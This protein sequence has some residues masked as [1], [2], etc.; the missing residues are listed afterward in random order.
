MKT[1]LGA[2]LLI[3][4]LA[5]S[6]VSASPE[7]AQKPLVFPNLSRTAL[8]NGLQV[9]VA[10]TPY[11]GGAMTIGLVLPCGSTFDPA[12]KGGAAYL[13][14][15]LLGKATIDLAAK[16]IQDELKYLDATLEV[17]CDWDGIR[18]LMRGRSAA[19][20][21][22]LLLLYR[23]VCEA[24]FN[25]DDFTRAQNALAQQLQV[26]QDLRRRIHS[27]FEAEL[28]R[29]TTYGRPI[30]GTIGTVKNVTVGDLRYFY[31]N[32]FSPDQAAI[33]IVGSVPE[34]TVIQKAR[35]IWGVW[36]RLDPV[37]FTFL[38]AREPG[39][40]N[41]FLEDDPAS[42]AAQYILGNLWPNREDPSYYAGVL[43]TRLLQERLSQVL[44][45]SQITAAAEGR[46]RPGPFY[47]QGQ[48]AAD[49][50]VEEINKILAAVE[51]FKGA[52]L[53]PEEVAKMQDQWIEE[54]GKGLGTTDGICNSVLDA[55]LYRLGM[56]YLSSFLDFVR[57][58]GSSAAIRDAA[59][60]WLFPGGLILVVRGPAS[61]LRPQLESVGTVQLLKN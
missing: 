50:A 59:K 29:D 43:A 45:T 10:S 48:A 51:T 3:F 7:S 1:R 31:K 41:I 33:T 53:K 24:K 39:A 46:R 52:D 58:S 19:Y 35:R 22:C 13:L 30:R 20:E 55:E 56:N 54:F 25:E 42:P 34:Q 57:R 17:Q 44:P 5:V 32:H 4:L 60:R 47:I 8:L 6:F 15:Q 11:L 37:P 9:Y 2:A 28:F 12:K 21:R 14:S 23:I 38:P 61:A 36:V 16:D 27:L 49:Q 26:P 40:R 18:L